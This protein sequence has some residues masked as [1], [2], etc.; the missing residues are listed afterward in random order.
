MVKLFESHNAKHGNWDVIA[1]GMNQGAS[2]VTDDDQAKGEWT[3]AKGLGFDMSQGQLKRQLD[4]LGFK[5]KEPTPNQV[6]IGCLIVRMS[7]QLGR[8]LSDVVVHINARMIPRP[9]RGGEGWGSSSLSSP[10]SDSLCTQAH[11]VV[12]YL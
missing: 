6:R 2:A 4:L 5:F 1:V 11:T 3:N 9:S 10:C 8:W 7:A 12:G